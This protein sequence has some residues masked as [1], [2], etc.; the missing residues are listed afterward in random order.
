VVWAAVLIS[1]P[2]AREALGDP[3][4]SY[5]L[6]AGVLA[7][8]SAVTWV[9]AQDW[10]W[11]RALIATGGAVGLAWLAEWAG[12]H[13][14]LLFGSYQYTPQFQPQLLG[15][16][17]LIPLAW[18]MMLPPAWAVAAEL[19]GPLAR[20]RLAFAA[21]SAA[22]FTAWDLLLDPQMVAWGF[23][24]WTPPGGYFGVPWSNYLGWCLVA[25]LLSFCFGQPRLPA[26]P[27]L[28]V[29]ALTWAIQTAGQLFFWN[30]P[31]SGL[32][33]GLVMG[34]LIAAAL[35]HRQ[36]WLHGFHKVS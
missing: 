19:L 30:Q 12:S 1:L 11:T 8:A 5:G 3:M 13:F 35:A 27:L 16:P 9:L 32:V 33:G 6:T 15:V 28:L 7:L 22:A 31:G 23:W 14:G 4:L 25:G 26:E 34:G 24:T 17:L 10:G 2:A 29:Y 20:R 21:V 18:W 36:G